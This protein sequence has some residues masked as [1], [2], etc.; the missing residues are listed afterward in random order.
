MKSREFWYELHDI[1]LIHTKLV[2][3]KLWVLSVEGRIGGMY[4]I[5]PMVK[6][7]II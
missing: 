1:R 7:V 2:E 3:D 6:I 4:F 5:I